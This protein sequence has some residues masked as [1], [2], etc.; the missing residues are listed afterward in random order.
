MDNISQ[1][2]NPFQIRKAQKSKSKLRMGLSGTSGSGKT[3]S[4]LLLASGLA[5]WNKICIIDTENGS[6]DLYESLGQFNVM[7]LGA[8]FTPERYIE[9]IKAAENAGM[10]VV[11]IDSITHEWDGKGGLLESNEQIAQSKFKGNTWAAW[12]QTTPR[13]Q[14]FIDAIV[15]SKC[16]LITTARSKQETVQIDG[17]IKKVGTKE[18]QREGF[19][20]ELTLNF[21][22]DRDSHLAI[23][24]KD[25]T[26]M[27]IDIDPFIITQETGKALKEYA[28][29][30]IDLEAI[31]KKEAEEFAQKQ[32][33]EAE[34][35]KKEK[36]I[37]LKKLHILMHKKGKDEIA[38]L[39]KFKVPS[40]DEVTLPILKNAVVKLESFPDADPSEIVDPD[41]AD[42]AIEEMKKK[43]CEICG[44]I[45]G[46]HKKACPNFRKETQEKVIETPDGDKLP[47]E[48]KIH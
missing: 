19:E 27:F 44:D 20:Y 48:E 12:S 7:T 16:H 6:A 24:S 15:S 4:A 43:P 32:R 25:R 28:E 8:P 14:K 2:N 40:L 31:A 9:A 37:V 21:N 1:N 46:Y 33:A 30:G 42:K 11:I 10:E 35:Y 18:I 29:S 22:I 17:K 36:A 47:L 23:A 38:M 13:H 39:E 41:E 3:Y 45:N 34:A 5:A 26:G